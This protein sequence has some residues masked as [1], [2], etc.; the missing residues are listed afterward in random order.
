MGNTI[1]LLVETKEEG[2]LSKAMEFVTREYAKYFN[3]KYNSAG[4]V[5]QGRFKSF[6]VQ[7]NEF[8]FPCTRAI[9]QHP[10]KNGLVQ[11]PK[12][13]EWSGHKQLAFGEKGDIALDEHDLYQNLGHT[14]VERQLVYRTLVA[15]KFGAELDLDNRKAG[16]LGSKE[17]KKA[18]K[19]GETGKDQK[20]RHEGK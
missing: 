19:S 18:V 20:T 5:F 12:A 1:H 2:S 4:H 9:D 14:P 10:V 15:Q 11:E 13:F 8:Y 17:F 6:T 16:I 7:D 3:T